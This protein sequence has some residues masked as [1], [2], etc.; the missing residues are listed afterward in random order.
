[1]RAY[2]TILQPKTV[3]HGVTRR[4]QPD[5]HFAKALVNGTARY[6]TSPP[7]M[8]FSGCR[9]RSLRGWEFK[10]PRPHYEARP[11][12]HCRRGRRRRVLTE[13]LEVRLPTEADRSTFVRFFGDDDFMVFS[14]GVLDED[15]ANR[16]FDEML[17]R[18]AEI[19]F[20]KQPVVER[21]TGVILGYSGVNWFEFE[22]E[23][24]LEW[25]YRL[26]PSARGKGYATE[27]GRALLDVSA[28]TFRGEILCMIDPKNI[29]SQ[30]VARKLGFT[31]WKQAV[32]GGWLD[33]L[34]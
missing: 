25:G 7:R 31:F 13:R 21:S 27:A 16:R 15:A 6:E 11:N 28:E 19:P 3:T 22:G 10:S 14:D 9:S 4:Y 17:V 18:A 20:A 23:Q 2:A 34:Y 24:R 5:G 29:P 1:M 32:I 26:M 8:A 12:R 30:N 33:N